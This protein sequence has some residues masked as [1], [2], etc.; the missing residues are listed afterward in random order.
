MA[1]RQAAQLWPI[2]SNVGGP[3]SQIWPSHPFSFENRSSGFNIH[4]FQAH[5]VRNMDGD[6]EDH[7]SSQVPAHPDPNFDEDH[8][9]DA[10]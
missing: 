9:D 8:D 6:N 7:A 4:C 2:G 10:S 3:N 1:Y 5:Y